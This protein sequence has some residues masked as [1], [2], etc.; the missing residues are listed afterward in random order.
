MQPVGK[1]GVSLVPQ[2]QASPASTMPLPQTAFVQTLGWPVQV[3]PGSTWHVGEHPLSV[4]GFAMPVS[5]VSLPSMT[6]SPQ[7]GTQG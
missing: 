3:Q 2:S 6:P 1:G 4:V 5:Q 7:I